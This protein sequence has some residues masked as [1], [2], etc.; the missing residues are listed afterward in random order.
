MNDT[1][2]GNI[3]NYTFLMDKDDV[4]E[5]W[6]NDNLDQAETYIFVKPGSIKNKKDFEKEIS[7]W[8]MEHQD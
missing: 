6:Y 7:F 3:G 4:I 8:W 1:Y 5:V 2:E